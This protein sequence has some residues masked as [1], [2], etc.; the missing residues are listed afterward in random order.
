MGVAVPARTRVLLVEDDAELARLYRGVLRLAGF[1]VQHAA[2]GWSALR[3]ADES[4]PDIVVLDIHLEGLRGDELLKEFAAHPET[5]HIPAIVVTGTD[6]ELAVARARHILYRPCPP[7]RL[8][9]A[10]ER[11][12][13]HAA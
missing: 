2:N 9:S 4:P 11:Y 7:D 5:R 1:D 10:V 8:L 3:L 6:I 13:E 12:V